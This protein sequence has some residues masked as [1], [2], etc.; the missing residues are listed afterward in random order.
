[1]DAAGVGELRNTVAQFAAT[2]GAVPAVVDAVRLTMSETLTNVVVHAYRGEPGPVCIEYW[3]QHECLFVVVSDEG[4]GMLPRADS[5]GLA[6][7]LPMVAQVADDF[8]VSDR[9]GRGTTIAARFSLD[10]TG[11]HS[12]N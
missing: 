4:E 6:L 1:M 8:R 12:A 2:V 7:G 10:G 11:T 5:P 9:P 3:T